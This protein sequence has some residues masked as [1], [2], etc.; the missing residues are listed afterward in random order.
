M[1]DAHLEEL[2]LQSTELAG[3]GLMTVRRDQVRLPS[4]HEGWR[5]Y[6]LHP[7]AVLIVPFLPNGNIL[8]ERQYRYPLRQ[9]FI[10]LPAGK[11]DPGEDILTTGQRELLEE[12][13]FVAANWVK[14]GLQHPC[15]GY[16][17]EVIHMY[18]ATGLVAKAHQRD[19]DEAMDLFELSL[20]DS[21]QMVMTGEITDSKTTVALMM[22][23][24]YMALH[25]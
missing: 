15:I 19:E 20:D 13:G 6:V 18:L 14:L 1:N 8:F 9:A 7:G 4:G 10:E 3:G 21:L 17:N 22:T 2:C 11:I 12:T 25:G 23:E 24:R 5:E 16:S